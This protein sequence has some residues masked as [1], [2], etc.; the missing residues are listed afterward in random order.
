MKKIYINVIKRALLFDRA[1]DFAHHHRC[2]KTPF[3]DAEPDHFVT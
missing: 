3:V 2:V 1:F